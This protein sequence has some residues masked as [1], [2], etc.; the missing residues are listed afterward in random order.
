MYFH[1]LDK[2]C[3]L[4]YSYTKAKFVYRNFIKKIKSHYVVHGLL[5]NSVNAKLRKKIK[6]YYE[7][8]KNYK[9]KINSYV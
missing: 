4:S 9:L 5:Y 7:K 8:Y 3:S 1:R 2:I 6:G